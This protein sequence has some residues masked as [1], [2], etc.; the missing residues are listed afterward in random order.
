MD[1][2][3]QFVNGLIDFVGDETRQ[4]ALALIGSALA[5][6]VLGVWYFWK[7]RRGSQFKQEQEI[8]D[9]DLR[10]SGKI[11]LTIEEYDRRL[12]VREGEITKE[13]VRAAGLER[14]ALE[15]QKNDL[16]SK[17]E[18][19][20]VSYQ[21]AI[22]KIRALEIE[23]S[24]AATDIGERRLSVAMKALH[25]GDYSLAS[26]IFEEVERDLEPTLKRAA[27]SAYGK[28]LIA[29]ARIDWF[30]A[31][32]HFQRS[33]SL[34][35]T[36]I[37]L[38]K[39]G[40]FLWR[41]GL[42]PHAVAA[43]EQLLKLIEERCGQHSADYAG[44]TN[45]LAAQLYELR[46]VD[47]AISKFEESLRIQGSLGMQDSIEYASGIFNLGN[48]YISQGK[49]E[50]AERLYRQAM[51]IAVKAADCDAE[52]LATMKNA[53]AEALRIKGDYEESERLF[54][55]VIKEDLDIH[56]ENHP[57]YARDLHFYSRLLRD[58][59]R[60]DEAKLVLIDAVKIARA[61]MGEHHPNTYAIASN[62]AWVIRMSNGSEEGK[63]T[64]RDL[65]EVF[66]DDVG[67][68]DENSPPP[69]RDP[70]SETS[71]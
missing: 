24:K 64:L 42:Y 43:S 9:G 6:I 50:T 51:D 39:A 30:G 31:A 22:S 58:I 52:R 14:K 60:Y 7:E 47:E 35:P 12:R 11:M 2:V 18:N 23:L 48:I 53:L 8:E 33:V 41:A 70:L 57:H 46:E 26:D 56:G 69:A 15:A 17:I 68:D 19:I 45:N 3:V 4:G 21:D 29:E 62:L 27:Q 5:A 55:V 32:E 36:E 16:V 20:E 37:N 34:Y 65:Q 44:A 49:I 38:H 28:G 1:W 54:K 25:S 66:G 40:L 59:G 13:I 10:S 67:L 71:E 61:T 63:I